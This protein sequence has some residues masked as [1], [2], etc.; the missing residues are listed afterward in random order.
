MRPRLDLHSIIRTQGLYMFGGGILAMIGG[1]ILAIIGAVTGFMLCIAIPLLL[2][3]PLALLYGTLLVVF[4]AFK[5]LHLGDGPTRAQALASI[6]AELQDPR[7][8]YQQTKHGFVAVTPSW[9][10]VHASDELVVEPRRNLLLAYKKTTTKRYGSSTEE[11]KIRT[12]SK[13][14]TCLTEPAEND[15]F[16][17][18]IGNAA[19]WA[20]LGYRPDWANMDRR[21]LAAQVDQRM[22]SLPR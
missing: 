5:L 19:P 10:L 21:A 14:Y 7:A 6:D 3:A 11:I 17:G 15:W 8:T 18:L 22:A 16:M 13:D 12:R 2:L 1:G 9:F 4:P 20:L